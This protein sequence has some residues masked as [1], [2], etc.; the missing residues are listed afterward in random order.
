MNIHEYQAKQ[1][2]KSYGA[3]VSDG[4]VVLKA[5]DAKTAAGELDGPLWVVKAQIHAGG[6]GKGH[7]KESEAGEKGGVRL[8]KSVEEAEMLTKQMLGKTLVTHQT[9]PAG[10]QVNRIYIEDGSDIERELYLALLVDRVT[11]RVSIVSSTEGGMDIE[12]V[13]ASTPEKILSFSVDPATGY[14]AFHGRRVAFSLGLQGPQVKQMVNLLGLLYKA[15]IEKDMEMLEINPLIVMTDGNLKVLDAK[16]G[17]D[18]NAM[19]R[20]H[21]VANLRDETEEDSKELEASKYDLN[22]IALDGEIGC[23][24][25]G[26]GLAM[27][28]MDIIKLYGAEPANFLDVGGGATKEKVTEAFKIITSDKNVKGI[29][30]NI[31]GGIMRCDII[32]EGV[33]AA[34]KEVG[35]KVPLVVRLE[36]TNV[37]KGKEIIANSGLNVIAADNLSDGA[38]KIVKAVKG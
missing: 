8:A 27:A 9:G 36:G 34:V 4:R 15:F 23:M 2:L 29:L 7:F 5:E 1:L 11:S 31:F 14:Q 17:F 20:Q 30:V 6:R 21:D 32:A 3:P 13:A 37:E 33:I 10:K 35:L 28:T 24:V 19:Y 18:G 22:Y 12:E 16:L 25:N 26:A 38:E